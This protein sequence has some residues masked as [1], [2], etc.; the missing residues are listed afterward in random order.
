MVYVC[1]YTCAVWIKMKELNCMK[2]IRDKVFYRQMIS[3]RAAIKSLCE[4]SM[5]LR[6]EPRPFFYGD[7]DGSDGEYDNSVY[8]MAN[9]IRAL[10][11]EVEEYRA[12]KLALA[13]IVK[14]R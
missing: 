10:V 3:K 7:R 9:D 11:R 5:A 6:G 12:L 8:S 2:L 1:P 13:P 14:G 4:I